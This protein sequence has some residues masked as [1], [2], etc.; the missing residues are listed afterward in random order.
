VHSSSQHCFVCN[1]DRH[2]NDGSSLERRSGQTHYWA[3]V[4]DAVNSETLG[5]RDVENAR[6]GEC[7]LA[8]ADQRG[9]DL[10]DHPGGS[11][12]AARK[13][14]ASVGPTYERI[15]RTLRSLSSLSN[16]ILTVSGRVF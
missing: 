14:P 9:C 8:A 7:W 12:P 13:D 1:F 11:V 2:G 3:N 15:A 5:V 16:A 4:R 10:S 6:I